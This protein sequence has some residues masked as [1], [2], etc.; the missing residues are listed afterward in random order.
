MQKPN[1]IILLIKTTYNDGLVYPKTNSTEKKKEINGVYHSCHTIAIDVIN[2][3]HF[4]M[5]RYDL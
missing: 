1:Q 4:C 3:Q 5:L 2:V